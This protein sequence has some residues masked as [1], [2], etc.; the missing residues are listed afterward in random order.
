MKLKLNFF[1]IVLILVL[2]SIRLY[3]YQLSQNTAITSEQQKT[4]STKK[5]SAEM[6]E[7]KDSLFTDRFNGFQIKSLPNWSKEPRPKSKDLVKLDLTS[8]DKSFGLQVR[9][10]LPSTLSLKKFADWYQEDFKKGMQN[11]VLL[12]RQEFMTDEL[13][14][15]SLS[16]DGTKRNGY[17][18]KSYIFKDGNI[19][20]ALQAGCPMKD[21]EKDEPIL[22][23][24]AKSFRIIP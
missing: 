15:I 3:E 9:K 7:I 12:S 19:F 23:N 10:F 22:D 20:F 1:L 14:G 21:K 11:P 4:V 18:L 24:I 13:T 16:F 6:I 8:S 2:G 5:F 17:F